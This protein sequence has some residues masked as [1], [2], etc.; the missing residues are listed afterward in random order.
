M[1]HAIF[2]RVLSYTDARIS[3]SELNKAFLCIFCF[4]LGIFLKLR[5]LPYMSESRQ[6][7]RIGK[8]LPPSPSSK[9]APAASGKRTR[10]SY[11]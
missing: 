10:S 7:E 9:R 6:I 3:I 5:K 2:C 1:R 4:S 8:G 11:K